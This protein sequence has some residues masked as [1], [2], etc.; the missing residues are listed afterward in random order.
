MKTW[1]SSDFHLG[2]NNIAGP[3]CSQWK[4]GYRDFNSLHEMNENILYEIN[5]VVGQDDVLYFLGDF[6]FGDH[7]KT[8]E[9]R[10]R[11]ICKNIFWLKGNHDRKQHLYN[12][13]FIWVGDVLSV[14][15]EKQPIFMSHY[16]HAIWEGSH[17]GYWHLYGHSHSSAENWEI[18]KSM[19]VGID[20][21]YKL[22]GEYRPFSFEEVKRLLDKRNLYFGDHHNENTN[23]R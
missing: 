12:D 14:I 8:L 6:C 10:A 18:G 1:F 5:K 13:G 15:I 21:A 4:N 11:I 20:N 3:S 16:K 17:K 22:L 7:R 9:W 2:H 19:D 23:V